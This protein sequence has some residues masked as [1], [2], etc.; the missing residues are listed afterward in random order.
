V[1]SLLALLVAFSFGMVRWPAGLE[2]PA[3][4][5]VVCTFPVSI[6]GT[7]LSY[8]GSVSRARRGL[9]VAGLVLS[10]LAVFVIVGVGILASIALSQMFRYGWVSWR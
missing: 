9:A 7:L 1:V 2:G 6:V 3:A 10:L 4:I 5:I 8:A